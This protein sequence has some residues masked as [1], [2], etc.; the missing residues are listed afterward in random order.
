[1]KIMDAFLETRIY[2]SDFPVSAFYACN[3]N[4]LAHWHL[5]VEMALV[6]TGRIRIGVN[7]ETRILQAGDLA[8]FRSMD[9]HYYD[10]RGMQ[11]TI[12]VLIFHPELVGS[13][14]GWPVNLQFVP[15]FIDRAL[16]DNMEAAGGERIHDLLSQIVLE[17]KETKPY[18][19]LYAGGKIAELC[20]LLLRHLPLRQ[21]VF[22]GSNGKIPDVRRIRQAIQY[23]ENHYMED[24]ALS[25]VARTLNLS[26]SYFSRV[27][28]KFTG[29]TFKK[30]LSRI[31]VE[32][33]ERLIQS[34]Q[35]LLIE[36]AYEC[37]FNS[38]RTFN[39]AFKAV[40][41][42]PPSRQSHF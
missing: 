33:A 30:Y 6:C 12:I 40:K 38:I 1:M 24:I 22:P 26:P 19:H 18:Y 13:P 20:A 4:F 36:V 10:S 16:L 3:N 11:S 8:I 23:L 25:D 17:L 5:D 37:G 9:I 7:E 27:F 42:Y 39:R 15:A 21:T 32:R 28:R 41:G 35:K 29:I 34:D 14:G 31:R 2:K